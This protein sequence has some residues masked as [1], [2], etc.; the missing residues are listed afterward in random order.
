MKT[1]FCASSSF[2][3]LV[4]LL[5]AIAG[6]AVMGLVFCWVCPDMS[7]DARGYVSRW[8][9]KRQVAW[10]VVGMTALCVA[11]VIGWKRW[12]KAA[13]FLFAGWVALWFAAHIRQS[14]D[15]SSAIVPIGP[16]SLEVWALFPVAFA[17]LAAWLR[18]RY[19]I[20]TRRILFIFGIVVFAVT[21][22]ELIT[23]ETRLNRLVSFISGDSSPAISPS[24][25]ARSFVQYQAGRA[26]AQAKWLSSS[27]TEI[28]RSLPGKMTYSMPAS[29]AVMFGKWFMSVA[30]GFF[31]VIAF[32]LAWL[33]RVT[34]DRA[35]R[36][37]ILVVGLGIIVPAVFG[38]CQCLG[39]VPMSYMSV[40]LVSNV[41]TAVLSSWLGAGILISV[42]VGRGEFVWSRAEYLSE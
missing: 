9:F 14:V 42:C 23:D 22:C 37:F 21:A 2:V 11:A 25:C 1:K 32:C 3:P 6:L 5:G 27:D 39:I 15:G 36:A 28:L 33:W 16:I 20:R 10:N 38:V 41:A 8:H 18:E 26:F 17:L 19:G 35:K 7:H 13:P 29:S 31:A 4:M 12:L 40:P 24:A 34:A 30:G